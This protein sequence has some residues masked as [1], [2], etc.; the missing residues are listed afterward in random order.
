MLG[1]LKKYDFYVPRYTSYPPVT[2]WDNNKPD[3]DTWTNSILQSLQ[4]GRKASVYVHIPFC[5]KL[6]SFC[7]CNKI[8]TSKTEIV[9][10]YIQDLINESK[11]YKNKIGVI[12]VANLHVGGG[13]P[14]YLSVEQFEKVFS[15]IFENLSFSQDTEIS[16]EADPRHITEEKLHCFKKLGFNRISYGIQD[17]NH[18]VQKT[19][20]RIQNYDLIA[21]CTKKAKE[22]GFKSINFDLVYGLPFQTED[23]IG[24]TFHKICELKPD[25]I[26]LYGYAHFPGNFAGHN[27]IDKFYIPS[28]EERHKLNLSAIKV[29]QNNEYVEIGMD[30]FA[31]QSDD[32][33]LASKSGKITRNFMGYTPNFSS[34]TIPLGVSS[35]GNTSDIFAQNTKDLQ[36]YQS[37]VSSGVIPIIKGHSIT[38]RQKEIQNIVLEIMTSFHAEINDKTDVNNPKITEILNDGLVK[39]DKNQIIVTTLGKSFLRH[40]CAALDP[41]FEVE[42]FKAHPKMP[43]N[44]LKH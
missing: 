18:E 34:V 13:T 27:H 37:L 11:L 25:R 36:Q 5:A 29:L 43:K 8:I 22:I 41:F 33:T 7:A 10:Q 24:E 15:A 3:E 40:I 1:L 17:T 12:N 19:I 16:L 14:N 31:T 32:L 38:K 39:I 35:I 23:S 2:N 21:Y 28:G 30:H 4:N 26:A 6:C 20:N 9:D 42:K 44:Q